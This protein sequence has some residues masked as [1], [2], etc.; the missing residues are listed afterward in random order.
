M[1]H[2]VHVLADGKFGHRGHAY[3]SL[4]EVARAITGARW[5]G[6]RFFGLTTR[7]HDEVHDDGSAIEPARSRSRPDR[8]ARAARASPI[9]SG[10]GSTL[11]RGGD[12]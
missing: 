3:A 5:S 2:E 7:M 9:G 4:S 11:G 6:P 12:A 1:R 10:R 8:S